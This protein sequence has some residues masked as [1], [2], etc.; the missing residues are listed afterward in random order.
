VTPDS[1]CVERET[2]EVH[3]AA[4][5]AAKPAAKSAVRVVIPQ[6]GWNAVRPAHVVLVSG[7]EG[8]LADRAIRQLRDLLKAED[9]SLEVNDLEADQY[10]PG[11]LMTMASPSLFAEPRFIRAVNVEKCTDAFMDEVLAYLQFPADDTYLV[12]R[13]AGG[14]RGKRMLDA[15]RGGLGDGIEIVCAEL[16][17]DSDKVEFAAAEF[18]A[19]GRR[20]TPGALRALVSAFT[21]DLAELAAA[22]QQLLADA[23]EEITEVTVEKYYS[24]RVETNAFKVADAAI[25]G[26]RGE[27]LVLLRHAIASGNDPVP[28]L[29]AFASKLRTM[30]K[31]S[32]SSRASAG[33]L[34][35]QLGLAPWMVD[36]ARR[37]LQG[38]SEEGLAATIELIAETDFQI[39]GGGRDAVYA[40]ERMI[41]VVANRGVL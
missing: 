3:M 41:G 28:M 7:T 8:F 1:V 40:L 2:V 13:H 23:S 11:E 22:C 35:S 14:V 30:A 18:S 20:I 6:L 37:D 34:A 38:W 29:A 19:A 21:D 10:L 33:Q 16:K 36:R 17:K 39:K 32:G 24:G 5:P 15:I 31:L 9:P 27:A 25:A 26:R 4:R 12:L